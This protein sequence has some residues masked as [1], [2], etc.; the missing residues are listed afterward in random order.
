MS[1]PEE[2]LRNNQMLSFFFVCFSSVVHHLSDLQPGQ[3]LCTQVA[4]IKMEKFQDCL[5]L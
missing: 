3:F 5:N 4:N 2:T 1:V